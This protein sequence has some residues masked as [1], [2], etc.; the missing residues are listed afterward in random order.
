MKRVAG[1]MS[2]TAMESRAGSSLCLIVGR[3]ACIYGD[4]RSIE[5][6]VPC[7]EIADLGIDTAFLKSTGVKDPEHLAGD[8]VRYVGNK[9]EGV[10]KGA[11]DEAVVAVEGLI[12][13]TMT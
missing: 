7:V 12:E 9:L 8:V 2:G 1:Q 11:D 6:K 3:G 10:I 4:Q 13:W 5:V